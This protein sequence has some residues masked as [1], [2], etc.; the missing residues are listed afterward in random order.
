M[1]LKVFKVHVSE[2]Q[3]LSDF[4][5]VTLTVMRKGFKKLQI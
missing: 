5:I 4:H 1:Y 2:R 3:G